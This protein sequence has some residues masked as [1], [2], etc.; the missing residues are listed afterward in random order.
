[1]ADS[2]DNRETDLHSAASSIIGSETDSLKMIEK[3]FYWVQDNVRYI[4]FEEGIMGYKPASASKVYDHLYGDC[5]GMANLT[6]IL[7]KTVGF[8]SRLTWIGTNDIPYNNDI[9]SLAVYNHMI[10]TVIF[11][12]KKYFLDPTESFIALGDYAERIQGRPC[13]VENGKNYLVEKVPDLSYE[14]NVENQNYTVRIENGKLLGFNE[15]Q[16]MGEPKTSFLRGYNSTKSNIKEHAVNAYLVGSN[17]NLIIKNTK[18]SDLNERAQPLKITYDFELKNS[19]LRSS[20][21]DLV[22]MLNKD[23]DLSRLYFDSTRVCDYEFT[24]KYN[25]SHNCSLKIPNKYKVGTAPSPLN[26]DND[27]FSFNFR[28]EQRDGEL[29]LV[30]QIKIKQA[31]I[32]T[33]DF[34]L[35]NK[36]IEQVIKFY[37]SPVILSQI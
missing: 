30:K 32:R 21:N 36:S 6:K 20:N 26:I 24:S 28:Y 14:R 29:R 13:M 27:L 17:S 37:N 15:C 33:S 35:W 22:I 18:T 10:C 3:I 12:G 23:Q 16:Y 5:K 4:A 7:L 25:I 31:V 2:V 11:K 8:D 19:V 1:L 34:Q 9:P